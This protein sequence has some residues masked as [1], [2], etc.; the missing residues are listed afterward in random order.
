MHRSRE[1]NRSFQ[2]PEWMQ[3]KWGGIGQKVQSFSFVGL[4]NLDIQCTHMMTTLN[5]M[6]LNTEYAK[7]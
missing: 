6:V 1:Q 3:G 4:I 5:N 2:V 7:C